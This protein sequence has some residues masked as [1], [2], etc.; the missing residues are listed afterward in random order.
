[1]HKKRIAIVGC[2]RIAKVFALG[3]QDLGYECAAVTDILPEAAVTLIF[4]CIPAQL[5]L[6]RIKRKP[7]R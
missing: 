7:A 5:V 4:L 6:E 1:M 3:I 2:G